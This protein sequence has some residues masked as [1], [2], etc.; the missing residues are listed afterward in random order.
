MIYQTGDRK[1][2]QDRS[3]IVFRISAEPAEHGA[4]MRTREVDSG[5]PGDLPIDIT[6][7]TVLTYQKRYVRTGEDWPFR[8]VGNAD[9]SFPASSPQ[10]LEDGFWRVQFTRID[11]NPL[12][13]N[14]Q[15]LSGYVGFA[16]REIRSANFL[17]PSHQLYLA[18]RKD[19]QICESACNLVLNNFDFRSNQVRGRLIDEFGVDY[20]GI[21]IEEPDN[22]GSA[23]SSLRA[24]DGLGGW[25]EWL[26]TRGTTLNCRKTGERDPPA[27]ATISTTGLAGRLGT[28]KGEVYGEAA[29]STDFYL[30]P[31]DRS[32]LRNV[33]TLDRYVRTNVN[34]MI[35]TQVDLQ[36][37]AIGG[38][39]LRIDGRERVLPSTGA[40]SWAARGLRFVFR[41]QGEPTY[42]NPAYGFTPGTA[43]LTIDGQAQSFD[44]IVNGAC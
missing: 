2:A 4:F 29:C 31:A 1:S 16:N 37:N 3:T 7:D 12:F 9:L 22:R 43:T 5:M 28:V 11:N 32:I 36:G 40:N 42:D 14:R 35:A 15:Q 10:Q 6:S 8:K 44:V 39:K 24:F 19:S 26:C 33:N 17:D 30:A 21:R 18:G 41:P 20:I 25:K 38:L 23:A 27:A 34:S 13:L